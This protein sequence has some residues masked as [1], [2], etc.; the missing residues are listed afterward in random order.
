VRFHLARTDV[1]GDPA[2]V[3]AANSHS[4]VCNP[5]ATLD[6]TTAPRRGSTSRSGSLA[7]AVEHREEAVARC[8]HLAASKTRELRSHDGVMRIEQRMQSRSPISAARRVESTMSVNST[9]ARTRSSA[10]SGC[11]R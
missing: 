5:A 8:V 2:D 11:C 1:H 9:V 4:P 3:V 7:E 10:T 6:A